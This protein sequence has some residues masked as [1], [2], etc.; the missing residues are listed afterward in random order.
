L[1]YDPP[2]RRL[3]VVNSVGEN[4]FVLDFSNPATP[5]LID[6]IR[7]T[8]GSPNSIDVRD[9]VLAVAV[10]S[11]NRQQ[12]GRV[13]FY[14]AATA[15]ATTPPLASVQVGALPDMLTFTPDGRRVLVANE[16]EPNNYNAGNIDPEG[17]VSI[18]EIPAAGVQAIT[19]ANVRTVDFR[20]L[21]GQEAAL[22]ARGVRIFGP[23][24]TAAQDLE[25]EYITVQGDTAYVVCQENNA[26]A[27]IRISTATLIGIRG[28]G[29]KNHNLTGF[30]L[31]PSDRDGAGGTGAIHIAPR[32]VFGIY[33]PDAINLMALPLIVLADAPLS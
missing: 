19:Q 26:I 30:G 6:S 21:N 29:L 13:F 25:P 10:D 16:G 3:F 27:L 7:F 28:L 32:P 14:R 12:P 18:I 11:T 31:D 33:Q 17:S 4:I 22:R 20:S 1:A 5:R 15:G 8:T 2:S 24:A 23:R 9:G